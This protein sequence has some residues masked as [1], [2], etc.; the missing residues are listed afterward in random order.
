MK[1]LLA[2]FLCAV[3]II[4]FCGFS[5]ISAEEVKFS[6]DYEMAVSVLKHI[7]IVT[8]FNTEN[9]GN[10]EESVTRAKFTEMTAKLLKA[11]SISQQIYF[12]DVKNDHRAFGAINALAE[13]NIISLADDNMFNPEDNITFEQALKI[14]IRA[15]GYGGYA[16]A[17]GGYPYGYI[18]TASRLELPKTDDYSHVI[19]YAEAVDLLFNAAITKIFDT[20]EISSGGTAVYK[21]GTETTLEVYWNIFRGKG[22]LTSYY[23]GN[24]DDVVLENGFVRVNNEKFSILDSLDSK[25]CFTNNIEFFYEKSADDTKTVI[26][27]ENDPSDNDGIIIDSQQ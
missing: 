21:Q 6:D 26:Y 5:D 1:R 4:P 14:L 13:K 16:E 15:I 22:R 18:K 8:E 24:M 12:S 10:T 23:G 19:N 11:N 2:L 9:G 3:M 17:N 27:M 20:S 7:G 25:T